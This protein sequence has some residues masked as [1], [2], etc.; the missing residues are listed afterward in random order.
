M[1]LRI[2]VTG[3]SDIEVLLFRKET[4]FLLSV[5]MGASGEMIIWS[6]S[7]SS[8]INGGNI[9]HTYVVTYRIIVYVVM[10]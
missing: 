5:G 9:I 7:A 10:L 6:G 8:P 3:G 4:W 1:M 2:S